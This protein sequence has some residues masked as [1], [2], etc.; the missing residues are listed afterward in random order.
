[1]PHPENDCEVYSKKSQTC[2]DAN[3]RICIDWLLVL[4][5]IMISNTLQ[6]IFESSLLYSIELTFKPTDLELMQDPEQYG[7]DLDNPAGAPDKKIEANCGTVMYK[8]QTEMLAILIYTMVTIVTSVFGIRIITHGKPLTAL[9]EFGTAMFLDQIKAIPFQ[10]IIWWTVIRR[11]GKFEEDVFE[12]WDDKE[13]LEGD[14]QLS[15]Y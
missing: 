3:K 10:L 15:L 11:C 13:I 7:E 8:C 9:I 12:E 6:V 2:F 1:M 4:W 14:T 5:A